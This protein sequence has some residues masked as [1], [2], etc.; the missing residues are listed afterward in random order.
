MVQRMASATSAALQPN[1]TPGAPLKVLGLPAPVETALSAAGA[2]NIMVM[3][4]MF[5]K[6]EEVSDFLSAVEIGPDDS[7]MVVRFWEISTRTRT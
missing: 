6:E 2:Q 7:T 4:Q 5:E 1:W 3:I